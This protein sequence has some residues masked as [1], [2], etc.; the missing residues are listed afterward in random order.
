M[1]KETY[2]WISDMFDHTLQHGKP[3]GWST[4][5]ISDILEK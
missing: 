5:R 4:N 3:Y 2:V 1:G